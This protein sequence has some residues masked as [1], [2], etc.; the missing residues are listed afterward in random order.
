MADL[1]F[2]VNVDGKPIAA[3][4]HAEDAAAV[5]CLYRK[6]AVIKYAGRVVWN[7]TKEQKPAADLSYDYVAQKIF[8]RIAEHNNQHRAKHE[9]SELGRKIITG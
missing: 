6:R 3:L 8:D 9:A 1:D 2:K 4:K 5:A 7:D